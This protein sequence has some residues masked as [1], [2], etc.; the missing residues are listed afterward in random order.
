MARRYDLVDLSLANSVGLSNPGGFAIVEKYPYS[1]EA[2]TSYIR[3][4]SDG[5]I[6]SATL[7][8]KEEPPKSALQFYATV[9]AAARAVDGSVAN[10]FFVA[11]TYLST[12][13]VLYKRGGFT[14]G[15][16]AKLRQHTRAMSFDEIYSPGFDFDASKAASVLDD[17]R[18]S[19]FTPPTSVDTPQ[20]A[21]ATATPDTAAGATPPASDD[22]GSDTLPAT[23]V[24]RLAWRA[25]V[26]GGWDDFAHRYV[27]D[28]HVLTNDRPYFA[29]YV[30]A[31]D[32][33]QAYVH[34]DAL[35]DDWGYLLIWVTFVVAC[36]AAMLL[37]LIPLAFGWRI[38]FSR[39]RGKT[40]TAVYFACLGLGYI[41]VEVGLISRFI[42]ALGTP[43]ISATVLI[44]GMLVSSGMGSLAAERILDRARTMLPGVLAS[45]SV[46]LFAYALWLDPVLA[47]TGTHAYAIRLMLCFALIAP[48]AFLMGFPMPTAMLLLA[49]LGKTEIFVWAWGVNGSLSVVG[50]AAVP[51]I[52]VTLGLAAVLETSAIAYLIAIPTSFA[53]LSDRRA[54][55]SLARAASA[56]GA[57]EPA[58]VL[59]TSG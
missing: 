6:L 48:P 26:N 40:G 9:A 44:T 36:L 1:L 41:V 27:F 18:A 19:I 32:L 42:L 34:L 15:E 59:P 11:S 56:D 43:T 22:N 30:K 38:V 20:G 45:I 2:L 8:N 55:Q 14:A 54:N 35:Q 51:I 10:S 29:G 13:T 5:G 17:Y 33:P 47:W 7:W 46:I 50:A 57:S 53:V 12:A 31:H 23:T 28:T 37:I 4:L 21:D 16:V 25:L 52:A 3:A 24:A 49:Q 58:R 39:S